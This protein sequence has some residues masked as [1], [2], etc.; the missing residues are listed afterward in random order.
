MNTYGG[1]EIQY[2][3]DDYNMIV[4]FSAYAFLWFLNRVDFPCVV[5]LFCS[6][7]HFNFIAFVV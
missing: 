6:I 7:F 3:K 2:I 1:I 4:L 5:P